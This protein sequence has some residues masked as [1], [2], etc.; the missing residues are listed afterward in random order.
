MAEA[1]PWEDRRAGCSRSCSA[2]WSHT[3]GKR[4]ALC[5]EDGGPGGPAP[6]RSSSFPLPSSRSQLVSQ[7]HIA[8]P[9]ASRPAPFSTRLL[10]FPQAILA[11]LV[12]S[13]S[14]EWT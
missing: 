1:E 2:S 6:P 8:A 11:A 5:V 12:E 10:S 9:Q 14:L 4:A 7:P 13:L 3:C